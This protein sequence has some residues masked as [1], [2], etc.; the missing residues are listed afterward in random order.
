MIGEVVRVTRI[1]NDF[2]TKDLSEKSQVSKSY[3]NEIEKGKKNPSDNILNKLSE[4]F[5]LDIE[6]LLIL[7]KYHDSLIGKKEKLEIYR[8]LLLKT[9]ETY[10]E[11]E[12]KNTNKNFLYIVESFLFYN[13]LTQNNVN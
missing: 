3:I 12:V 13:N 5:N 10:E 7:N 8:M 1:A 11:K 9:L 2:T 4:G 6:D